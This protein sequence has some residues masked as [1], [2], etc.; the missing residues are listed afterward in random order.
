MTSAPPP[1]D[2]P[3]YLEGG[4]IVYRE[5]VIWGRRAPTLLDLLKN[6]DQRRG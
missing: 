1:A 6:R 5:F 3:G 4:Q 2:A